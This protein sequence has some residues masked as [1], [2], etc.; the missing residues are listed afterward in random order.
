MDEDHDTRGSCRDHRDDV[1]GLA[2]GI[3]CGRDRAR[4]LLHIDNCASCS[5]E[6]ASLATVADRVLDLAPSTEPPISFESSVHER[7]GLGG[8]AGAVGLTARM[9]TTLSHTLRGL[10]VLPARPKQQ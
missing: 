5:Y 7:L 10:H 3:L 4:A 1:V 8:S 2:L 9:H 6:L